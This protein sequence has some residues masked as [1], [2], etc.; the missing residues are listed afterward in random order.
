MTDAH[1]A[2][3]QEGLAADCHLEIDQTGC[4]NLTGCEWT[5]YPY[6]GRLTPVC[7][8]DDD[9]YQTA[10]HRIVTQ[11]EAA[12]VSA[13]A[14]LNIEPY[15]CEGESSQV[16]AELEHCTWTGSECEFD[17]DN[18]TNAAVKTTP[19]TSGLK[20]FTSENGCDLFVSGGSTG[21]GLPHPSSVITQISSTEWEIDQDFFEAIMADPRPLLEDDARIYESEWGDF[22]FQDVEEGSIAYELGFRSGTS[23]S[24]STTITCS[25]S[26]RSRRRGMSSRTRGLGPSRSSAAPSTTS[27]TMSSSEG[28]RARMLDRPGA[29]AHGK[30]ARTTACPARGHRSRP[31]LTGPGPSRE[32]GPVRAGSWISIAVGGA[33]GGALACGPKVDNSHRRYAEEHCRERIEFVSRC[34]TNGPWSDFLVQREYDKCVDDEWWD[35]TDECGELRWAWMECFLTIPCDHYPAHVSHE[36]RYC[37]DE[38]RGWMVSSC[39]YTQDHGG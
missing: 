11:L 20:C 23:S 33:L 19:S 30:G 8:Y 22:R 7:I 3:L 26:S 27:S 25:R 9:D 29:V 13:A 38:L 2:I 28:R 15:P 5:N 21:G 12:C 16:C 24:R 14:G 18:C 1:H 6:E 32:D 31:S 36:R 37:E 34:S 35:W 4:E 39:L 10:F 17:F